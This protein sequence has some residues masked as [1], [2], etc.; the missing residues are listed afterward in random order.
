M[1]TAVDRVPEQTRGHAASEQ[2]RAAL[3][4]VLLTCGVLYSL[5]YVIVN[6]VVA[7]TLYRGYSRIS[8]AISE[9]SATGA[10]TRPLL[11]ATLPISTILMIAFGIGVWRSARGRRALRATGVVLGTF[12]VTGILWLPF[13]MTSRDEMVK[14]TMAVND[15]GHIVLTAVTVLFILAQIVF[16]AAAFGKRFRAY[17]LVTAATVL[18]FGALTG[19]QSSHLPGPTPWM[20]LL[21]R[22]SIGAWLL[23]MVVLAVTLLRAQRPAPAHHS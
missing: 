20:G 2:S 3:S 17:S 22:I 14:G 23:W 1:S 4:R 13:P 12:S 7:A 11:T 18:V 16:G 5:L 9:L 6:D 8:Q 15:V 21:E 10:P 19:V